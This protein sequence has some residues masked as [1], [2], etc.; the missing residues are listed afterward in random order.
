MKFALSVLLIMM[1]VQALAQEQAVDQ[2]AIDLAA[3]AQTLK[4]PAQPLNCY[5]QINQDGQVVEKFADKVR[6]LGDDVQFLSQKES[7]SA[8]RVSYTYTQSAAT[9]ANVISLRVSQVSF[10][11]H[12][13]QV[14]STSYYSCR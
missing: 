14:D 10:P 4:D 6:F 2:Q 11:N 13:Y 12:V 3:A 8:Q 5:L 7:L 9:G 1:S